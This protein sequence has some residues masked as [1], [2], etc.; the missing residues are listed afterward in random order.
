MIPEL[1]RTL[2]AGIRV[3]ESL[4]LTYAI[5]GGLAVS[6]WAVPRATRDV[7]VYAELPNAAR[8]HLQER[9]LAVGFDVPAM[10][11]ELEHFGVFRS[12]STGGV[13]LDVFDAVGPLGSSLLT[14][15]RSVKL[16]DHDLWLAAPDDVAILKAFSD[17]PRDF[18]D[19]VALL[20]HA[21]GQIDI[22]YLETW[23]RMLD[24]SI[25]SDEVTERL[26]RARTIAA[27]GR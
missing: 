4:D 8:P 23:A 22:S 19:L 6:T 15:R 10:E 20:I 1:E 14:R 9:L 11:A 18:E 16:G 13:F 27:Q 26:R 21:A 25:E 17:R 5:V 7:D 3:L 12:R 2:L 24:E